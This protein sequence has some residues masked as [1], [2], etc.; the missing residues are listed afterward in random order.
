[1]GRLVLIPTLQAN[2][3][4]KEEEGRGGRE[5]EGVEGRN[6]EERG[7][8]ER[9]LWEEEKGRVKPS[10]DQVSRERCSRILWLEIELNQTSTEI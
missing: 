1:M 9:G 3:T 6:E 4:S 8:K 7:G 10:N 2:C 5:D